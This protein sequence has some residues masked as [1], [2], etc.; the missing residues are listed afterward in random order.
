MA[1][2]YE[3]PAS[4]TINGGTPSIGRVEL[5]ATAASYMEALPKFG[6]SPPTRFGHG[7][8]L[9]YAWER[10]TGTDVLD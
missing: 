5:A 3:E 9:R 7:E 4:L 1:A 6:S 2:C 8:W 10:L